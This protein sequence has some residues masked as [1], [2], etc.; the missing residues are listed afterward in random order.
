M[1]ADCW[2]CLESAPLD[3]WELRA[4]AGFTHRANS[5]WPLGALRRPLT[6]A[7][8]EVHAWYAERGL[9]P[10]VQAQV[11]SRF[12]DDLAE[13]GCSQSE[14]GAL[15]QTANVRSA[16]RALSKMPYP[17]VPLSTTDRPQDRWLRLYR[18]GTVPPQ[19]KEI[20][21]SGPRYFYATIYDE[22]S[23][24]P[25]SIG[26]A[27]LAGKSGS[28]VGL[29]AIETA[30][31][32]RRHGLASLV[33]QAL[34]QWAAEHGAKRAMLEVGSGNEAATRLYGKIGFVT[35]H[36]YHYRAVP[37]PSSGEANGALDVAATSDA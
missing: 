31:E 8:A 11:G 18:S 37:D 25:L 20:L 30:P 24:E 16:L 12:D 19:A 4:G 13:L 34:L 33:V 28:W 27:V 3:G 10:L 9:R 36:E 23:G 7:L 26:R 6:D 22:R 21:G 32:S 29:A 17:N 5:A 35:A 14:G 1:A 2:G 15:R